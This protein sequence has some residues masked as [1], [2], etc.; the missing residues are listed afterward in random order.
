MFALPEIDIVQGHSYFNQDWDAAQYTMQDTEHLMRGFGKP[1]FF[2][3]QGIEGRVGN[4]PEGKHF[5]DTIWASALSGA[6]GTGLYWWWHNYIE[7]FDLYHHYRP[8]A[9]FVGD[10]D[11]AARQW[12]PPVLTRPSLPVTLNVYGL[13][14]G[15]RALLWLHD[16]LGFRILD[17]KAVKGPAQ[18]HASAN[19]AGLA[20]GNYEIDYWDTTTGEIL[21]R[22]AGNVN[23][24]RHTG[25]GI[26]LR[27]P[28]FWGDI[29][30]RVSRKD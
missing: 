27:L 30:V 4:D 19:V 3:E 13:V 18:S 14:A 9:K 22:A 15:D 6:A 5:H 1:F 28:D 2:G 25:Y 29:A 17:G 11:F 23:P 16:P 21:A 20:P 24:A 26:E 8:L 10:E 7:P 12:K